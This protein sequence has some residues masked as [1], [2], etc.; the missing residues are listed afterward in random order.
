MQHSDQKTASTNLP[1]SIVFQ[2]TGPSSAT[3]R[4]I[5]C[6]PSGLF[7]QQNHCTCGMRSFASVGSGYDSSRSG[8]GGYGYEA[9]GAQTDGNTYLQQLRQWLQQYDTKLHSSAQQP[10]HASLKETIRA[11]LYPTIG[12]SKKERAVAIVYNSRRFATVTARTAY[13]HRI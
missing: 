8:Y 9:V 2:T 12:P 13:Y 10:P 4:T 1:T 7:N 6:K 11:V 3:K 5:N